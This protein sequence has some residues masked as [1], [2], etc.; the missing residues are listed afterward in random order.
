MKTFIISTIVLFALAKIYLFIIKKSRERVAEKI[1]KLLKY[2]ILNQTVDSIESTIASKKFENII[3]KEND[4]NFSYIYTSSPSQKTVTIYQFQNN[5]CT[6]FYI[7]SFEERYSLPYW[8]YIKEYVAK[9]RVHKDDNAGLAIYTINKFLE[10]Y[11]HSAEDFKNKMQFYFQTYY[12]VGQNRY[13]SIDIDKPTYSRSK[14]LLYLYLCSNNV[15]LMELFR[16]RLNS[17]GDFLVQ[18]MV[19][20]SKI[21]KK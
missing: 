13:L 4:D 6:S 21:E 8:N 18:F 1:N 2:D 10:P 14:Y 16:I 19:D 9:E 20:F 7:Q 3:K 15:Q 11:E 5:I 17:E 12:N